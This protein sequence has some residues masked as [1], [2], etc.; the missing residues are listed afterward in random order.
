MARAH[1]VRAGRIRVYLRDD[2]PFGGT[3]PPAAFFEYPAS[4]HGGHPRAH[5][6]G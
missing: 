4:R 2:R 1:V 3:V 5:L 6:A